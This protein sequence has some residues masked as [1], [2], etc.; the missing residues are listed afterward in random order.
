MPVTRVAYFGLAAA[1]LAV[2]WRI[3]SSLNKLADSIHHNAFVMTDCFYDG[4]PDGGETVET[5]E[6]DNVITITR[7]PSQ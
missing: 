2:I 7:K 5:S 4:D 6:I 1:S 3:G